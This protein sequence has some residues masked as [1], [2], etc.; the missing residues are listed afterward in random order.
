MVQFQSLVHYEESRVI[1]PKRAEEIDCLIAACGK[2]TS[3]FLQVLKD[4]GAR[5]S[6]ALQLRW[7]DLDFK[8]NTISI[9]RPGKGSN[10]RTIE[11]SPKTLNM[12][13]NLPK[14]YGEYIFKQGNG[15]GLRLSFRRKR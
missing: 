11:V 8:D 9:N 4:T 13:N 15:E 6:E 7:A 5:F 3:V 10:A 2:R 12:L 1:K 14:K